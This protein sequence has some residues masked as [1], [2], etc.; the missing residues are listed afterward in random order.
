MAENFDTRL[1]TEIER[2]ADKQAAVVELLECPTLLG[3]LPTG[4][5]PQRDTPSERARALRRLLLRFFD[6]AYETSRERGDDTAART[7]LAVGAL[8]GMVTQGPSEGPCRP[9]EMRAPVRDRENRQYTAGSWLKPP[10]Q[11]RTV[12]ANKRRYLIT[13]QHELLEYVETVDPSYAVAGARASARQDRDDVEVTR[14]SPAGPAPRR[15]R[16]RRAF[17]LVGSSTVLA[18]TAGVLFVHPWSGR[19]GGGGDDGAN[20]G[21]V[22]GATR[23]VEDRASAHAAVKVVS[24]EN[25]DGGYYGWVFD[26]PHRFSSAELTKVPMNYDKYVAW[27][28]DRGA[29]PAYGRTDLLTL[30]GNSSQ[31]VEINGLQVDKRCRPPLSGAAFVN[32]NAGADDTIRLALDLDEPIP[33]PKGLESDGTTSPNYFTRHTIS[34]K[35]GERGKIVIIATAQRNYCEYTLNLKVTAGDRT[36]TQSVKDNGK[37][38]AVSAWQESNGSH[39]YSKYATAY[40]GGVLNVCHG[41]RGFREVDPKSYE[42]TTSGC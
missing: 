18:M 41:G 24:V 33:T 2:L 40:V 10:V 12:R 28:R 15:S 8:M 19:D 25:I 32:P 23:S 14:L 4:L 6:T 16:K 9:S 22:T 3:L 42:T 38:F 27:F 39:P 36:L 20:S 11:P 7:V 5:L 29:V 30:E 21:R 17:L 31:P 1:F 35:R 26:R 13:F 37:P 34:L